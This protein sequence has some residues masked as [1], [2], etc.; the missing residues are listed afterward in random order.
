MRQSTRSKT[1]PIALLLMQVTGLLFSQSSVWMVE[2]GENRIYIGGTVHALSESDYPLPQEFT[3]AYSVS[4][5]LVIETDIGSLNNPETA[6]ILLQESS[7]QDGRTLKDL[8]HPKVYKNLAAALAKYLVP[9]DTVNSYKPG[10]IWSLLTVLQL[11]ESGYT[12]TG[13]DEYFFNM[14]REE[15]RPVLFLETVEEQMDFISGLGEG[16]ENDF[17]LY[18]LQDQNESADYM[19]QLVAEWKAGEGILMEESLQELI[20]EHPDVEESLLSRRNHKWMEELRGFLDD[21]S[22]EFILFGAMHLYGDEGVLSLLESEGYLIEQL[23][24]P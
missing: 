3:Y 16:N 11:A 21:G 6:G 24:L 4:D 17:V 14:A 23:K 18:L 9:I 13:V 2:N 8:L 1:L 12:A 10:F 7:Y 5:T 19:E 15:S 22:V 20:H